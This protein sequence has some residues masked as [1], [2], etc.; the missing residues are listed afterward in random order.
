MDLDSKKIPCPVC[1]SEIILKFWRLWQDGDI[2]TTEGGV[3]HIYT[4]YCSN[5][6]NCSWEKE[7]RDFQ[8][9]DDYDER[10]DTEPKERFF[11]ESIMDWT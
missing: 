2:D 9:W 7:E 8:V 5:K 6:K 1:G 11:N 3:F 4:A 10:Y